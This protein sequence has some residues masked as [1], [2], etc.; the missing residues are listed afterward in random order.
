LRG[1]GYKV[2]EDSN[3][4]QAESG[5]SGISIH[6]PGRLHGRKNSALSLINSET[7]IIEYLKKHKIE[8][9]HFLTDV[10]NVSSIFSNGILSLNRVR[11]QSLE[12]RD[13]SSSNVQLIREY[14]KPGITD[15]KNLHH[16]VPLY[17]ATQTPTQYIISHSATLRGRENIISQD[18]L[19]FIDIDPLAIFTLPNVIFTDG[20]AAASETVFFNDI[21]DLDKIDWDVINCPGDYY[22]SNGRCYGKEWK[23][24]KCS[25]V[26]VPNYISVE[27]FSRIV[28]FSKSGADHFFEKINPLQNRVQKDF[29]NR[30]KKCVKY[31]DQLVSKYYF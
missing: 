28:V 27:L 2:K 17:F 24:I 7:K 1:R 15:S 13:I 26:L 18:M 25:E 8:F 11:E 30:I 16:Y 19:V 5:A 20:N 14:K 23:R 9:L 4:G 12:F 29:Y 6:T 10:N 21:N 22:G 31:S 3:D